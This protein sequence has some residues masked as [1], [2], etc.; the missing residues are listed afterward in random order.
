ME[1]LTTATTL[2][3]GQ[4]LNLQAK[5]TL[6]QGT[7]KRVVGHSQTTQ[8]QLDHGQQWHTHFSVSQF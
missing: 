4:A 1:A 7:I 8:S 6:A 2:T 3:A 5:V